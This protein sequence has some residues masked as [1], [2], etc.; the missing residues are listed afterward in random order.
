M[1]LRRGGARLGTGPKRKCNCGECTLC[2]ERERKR[3]YDRKKRAEGLD[4]RTNKPIP[5]ALKEHE[6]KMKALYGEKKT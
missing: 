4:C 6:E 3:Q 5:N 1:A 2:K